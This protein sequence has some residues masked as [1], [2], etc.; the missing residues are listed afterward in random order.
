M[1]NLDMVANVLFLLAA[2]IIYA[3][4]EEIMNLLTFILASA[5]WLFSII[6]P[7]ALLY[8]IFTEVF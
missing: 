8:W 5:V 7:F 3:A 4:R 1:G 2:L 6:F